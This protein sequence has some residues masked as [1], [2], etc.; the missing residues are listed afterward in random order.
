[1]YLGIT[2]VLSGP[3][4]GFFDE[5]TFRHIHAVLATLFFGSCAIYSLILSRLMVK[6][7]DKFLPSDQKEINTAWYISTFLV[8]DVLVFVVSLI[9]NGQDYWLT[10]FTE[11]IFTLIIFTYFYASFYSN[12]FYDS[13]TPMGTLLSKNQS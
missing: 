12:P 3:L 4:V 1:M 2:A 11:W 6:Y 5:H 8:C 13:V 10:P 9:I 7:Q